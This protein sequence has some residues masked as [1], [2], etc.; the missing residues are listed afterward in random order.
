[1][2][3]SLTFFHSI[4][5]ATNTTT[6]DMMKGVPLVLGCFSDKKNVKKSKKIN[7]Y[8]KKINIYN[9]GFFGNV[10]DYFTKDFFFFWWPKP[11]L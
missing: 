4:L 3:C 6:L 7:F 10:A 5:G 8:L 11:V 2:L 1:M 9:K